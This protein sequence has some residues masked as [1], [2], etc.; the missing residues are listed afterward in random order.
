MLKLKTIYCTN[1]YFMRAYIKQVL[2][3]SLIHRS[4]I[5]QLL[6]ISN[7]QEVALLENLVQCLCT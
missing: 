3:T 5:R 1:K 2:G 4:D 7:Q 6:S